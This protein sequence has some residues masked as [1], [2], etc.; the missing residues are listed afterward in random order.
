M[1]Q[2]WVRL[3][4][5][6]GQI[7]DRQTGFHIRC[8]ERK[9]LPEIVPA[10]SLTA[11]RLDAHGLI[12]CDPPVGARH[13]VPSDKSPAG[14]AEPGDR[15]DAKSPQPPFTKGGQGGIASPDD[16]RDVATEIIDRRIEFLKAEAMS[17]LRDMAKDLDVKAGVTTSKAKLATAIAVAEWQREHGAGKQES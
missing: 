9:P 13:A 10:G 4:T 6:E 11:Q 16:L 1:K 17:I 3:A 2:K 12:E 14:S 7:Y 5:G 8:D 15:S